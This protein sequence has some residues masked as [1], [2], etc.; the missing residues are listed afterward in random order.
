MEQMNQQG[1]G[2]NPFLMGEDG[3]NPF[4]LDDMT[5]D[6]NPFLKAFK[7]NLKK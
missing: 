5:D 4:L 6:D 3:E 2:E 1:M 7:S